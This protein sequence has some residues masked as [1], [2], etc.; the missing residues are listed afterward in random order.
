MYIFKCNEHKLML[1]TTNFQCDIRMPNVMR[2]A[3]A[4]LYNSFTDVYHFVH[5]VKQVC[6]DLNGRLLNQK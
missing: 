6:Y 3:P 4:P 5:A 2:V 1:F